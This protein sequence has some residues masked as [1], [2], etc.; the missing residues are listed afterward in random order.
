MAVGKG[1][2][3]VYIEAG[4]KRTF[5]AALDWPGWARSGRDEG[6]ALAA[7][8][9]Y[10]PRYARA[11]RPARPGFSAPGDLS[12]LVVV[13]R[14]KGNATTDYG[15]P[16]AWPAFDGEPLSKEDLRRQ[17]ALLR[18]AWRTFDEALDA[19]RGKALS[20]GPRG[21]GRDLASIVL[22]TLEAEQAYLGRLGWPAGPLPPDP[23]KAHARLRAEIVAGLEAS[24]RGEIPATGPRGGRRWSARTFVR[25]AG[26][27]ALDHAWEIEDR[28]A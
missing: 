25:R 28:S 10:G 9:A 16:G 1:S 13:E 19:A 8:S 6:A 3:R 27:H 24:A 21:G 14:L 2:V 18:A 15:A 12:S 7:L 5:A 20:T 17:L 26:W 22:H 23:E 4:T 11:V